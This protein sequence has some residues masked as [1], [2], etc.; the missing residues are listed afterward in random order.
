M[1]LKILLP[2]L[3]IVTAWLGG[4]S[5]F[6]T[7]WTWYEAL[8]KA[9]FNPPNYLFGIVWPILYTIMGAVSYFNAK[10]IY[11]L[12]MFQLVL[13]GAWSW[14]FFAH[15]APEL[16][17]IN[18]AALIAVNVLIIKKLWLERSFLSFIGY[19][20]YLL[21]LLFASY[22]NISISILN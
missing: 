1:V 5:T 15:Q 13:N 19:V 8:N 16:A 3:T 21:W 18:I 10:H 11:K 12:Y 6:Y 14:I 4:L 2:L 9:T 20:P 22:L 7:D 17:F